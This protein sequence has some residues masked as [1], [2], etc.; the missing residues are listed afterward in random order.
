MNVGFRN[1]RTESSQVSD[2]VG[3]CCCSPNPC[4]RYLLRLHV[5]GSIA[6][7]AAGDLFAAKLTWNLAALDWD[8]PAMA[9]TQDANSVQEGLDM[10]LPWFHSRFLKVPVW[11]LQTHGLLRNSEKIAG[12]FWVSQ[13]RRSAKRS[14]GWSPGWWLFGNHSFGDIFWMIYGWFRHSFGARGGALT[15]GHSFVDGCRAFDWVT[16]VPHLHRRHDRF[17]PIVRPFDCK[18]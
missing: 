18:A 14:R 1:P 9:S 6:T 3:F 8:R 4:G 16:L 5:L 17:I 12:S 11:L 7:A 15:W 2:L 10:R 13:M